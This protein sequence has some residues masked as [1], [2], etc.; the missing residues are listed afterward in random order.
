MKIIGKIFAAL[1]RLMLPDKIWDAV[2]IRANKTKEILNSNKELRFFWTVLFFPIVLTISLIIA[3]IKTIA[4]WCMPFHVYN[5]AKFLFNQMY[6]DIVIDKI[7]IKLTY[8]RACLLNELF[9]KGAEK[10]T[11]FGTENPDKIFYVLRPYYYLQRNELTV[12]V[13]NLLM[14][15]YRNLQHLAY[16]VE[17]GWIPVVDWENYGPFP[18]EENYPV[19]GTENCWEYYWNQPSEYTLEEVYRSKNVILSVQN[20]RDNKYVPSCSFRAP[21]QKQAEDY[22]ERCPQYDKLITLNEYTAKYIQEKQDKLFPKNARILGVAVRGTS[23]GISATKNNV[24]GHPIQPKIGN[25]IESIRT[26][27][28]EWK[29]DYVF[30]TCE[31]DSVILEI[32]NA[33]E[34]KVLY[35]S[36]QRYKTP[37]MRGDIE[38]NL[39][40][41]Y[42]PGQKYQTNLDYLTEMVLLSRCTSLLAAMS[43]GVRAAIIWNDKSYEQMKIFDNGLW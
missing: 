32:E 20:T 43:S 25:L 14:H 21:L 40:P 18:H 29:M 19:N 37:P 11:S 33:F 38:K 10:R 39:D 26:T 6:T 4:V 7:G 16:A 42:V 24:N 41:L 13:S 28:D 23:Y 35:L 8:K 30:I 15:Y 5:E 22:A 34:G 2:R 1:L 9:R 36:R 31:L 27:M 12:N 17:K 3:V